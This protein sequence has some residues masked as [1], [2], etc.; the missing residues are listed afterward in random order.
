V[1]AAPSGV[2]DVIA[3]ACRALAGCP[4]MLTVA[5]LEDVAEVVERPNMPGT[6]GDRWPN[7][8]LALPH[9]LEEVLASPLAGSVAATL[10]RGGRDRQLTGAAVGGARHG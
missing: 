5:A 7:W 4:S 3:A 10:R 8:S 6:T 9:P 2:A 1:G